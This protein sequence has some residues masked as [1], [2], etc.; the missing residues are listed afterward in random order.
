MLHHHGAF[1]AVLKQGPWSPLD[2]AV[3]QHHDASAGSVASLNPHAPPP[4]CPDPESCP[5]R[6][7]YDLNPPQRHELKSPQASVR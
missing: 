6:Y 1:R 3:E 5:D 2:Q 4:S 7:Q